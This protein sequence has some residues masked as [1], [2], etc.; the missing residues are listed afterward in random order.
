MGQGKIYWCRRKLSIFCGSQTLK[1]MLSYVLW[2]PAGMERSS[3]FCTSTSASWIIAMWFLLPFLTLH[4]P[5]QINIFGPGN[6][7]FDSPDS[8]KVH[9]DFALH[10][11]VQCPCWEL[12]THWWVADSCLPQWKLRLYCFRWPK[13]CF[14]FLVNIFQLLNE[15][16]RKTTPKMQLKNHP[17]ETLCSSA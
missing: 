12:Q 13:F 17:A 16:L 1:P 8:S 4:I 9:L 3:V 5:C 11:G 15:N 14:N 10:R 7:K 6:K 2:V